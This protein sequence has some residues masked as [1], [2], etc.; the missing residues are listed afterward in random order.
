M[1]GCDAGLASDIEF[2]GLPGSLVVLSISENLRLK[3]L[4]IPEQPGR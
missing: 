2:V 1:E 3:L 4:T